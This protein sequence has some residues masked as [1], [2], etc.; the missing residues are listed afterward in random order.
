M[1]RA[2][3]RRTFNLTL[4]AVAAGAIA[5]SA[6]PIWPVRLVYNASAS[7]PLG[8]Y[9]V[10]GLRALRARDLVLARLPEDA[11]RWLVAR[12]YIAP[13]VPVL[14]VLRAISGQRVC[15][16]GD[17]VTIDNVAVGRA[18]DEDGVGRPLPRWNGCRDLRPGDAF[19]FN[20][21]SPDSFD[22]RYFGPISAS[23]IIGKATPIWTW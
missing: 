16:V 9:A 8:W 6:A 11:E 18:R 17:T 22:G 13:R 23:R 5:V 3:L 21:L 20:A 2:D 10:S 14:K 7:V 19:L 4:T 12:G 1:T 15:R